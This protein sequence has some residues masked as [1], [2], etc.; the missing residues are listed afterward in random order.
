MG[1]TSNSIAA[2]LFVLALLFLGVMIYFAPAIVAWKRRHRQRMAIM[3]LTVLAG[4][5][6]IGWVGAMVWAAT[7]DV[8]PSQPSKRG[9]DDADLPKPFLDFERR[10]RESERRLTDK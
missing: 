2:V 1:T 6:F 4:W 7:T 5:T 9:L 8:E 3:V 10:V